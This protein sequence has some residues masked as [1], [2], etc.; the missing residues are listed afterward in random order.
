MS[1]AV[2]KE[3]ERTLAPSLRREETQCLLQQKNFQLHQWQQYCSREN[4]LFLIVR[5]FVSQMLC[6]TKCK[7]DKNKYSGLAK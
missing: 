2:V 7:C 1:S 4:A 3:L 6:F 5:C